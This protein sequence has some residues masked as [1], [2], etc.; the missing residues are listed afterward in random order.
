VRNKT[1]G[2]QDEGE[3]GK[4]G[5]GGEEHRGRRKAGKEFER[6]RWR[7]KGRPWGDHGV[8]VQSYNAYVGFG[9]ARAMVISTAP[10]KCILP[11]DRAR[12]AYLAS[13]ATWVSSVCV[14]LCRTLRRVKDMAS[15]GSW[16][17]RR[18][19]GPAVEGS[20]R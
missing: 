10:S 8:R 14:G 5:G 7:R 1:L 4:L 3:E 16:A 13:V 19:D 20:V 2:H 18:V 15:I 12:Y 6:C 17:L 11:M 9:R